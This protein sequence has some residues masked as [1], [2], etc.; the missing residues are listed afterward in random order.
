MNWRNLDAELIPDESAWGQGWGGKSYTDEEL[1]EIRSNV[2][3]STQPGYGRRLTS[4]AQDWKL[5]ATGTTEVF[6]PSGYD[7]AGHPNRAGR[8]LALM[9][10]DLATTGR[11][12][13]WPQQVHPGI[14]EWAQ[15]RGWCIDQ[16]G[17]PLH[18]L[19]EQLLGDRSIGMPTGLG[20][21]WY[22]GEAVVV[23]AVVT[24]RG[25]TLLIDRDTDRGTIPALSGGYATPADFGRTPAQWRAGDR[26]VT[27]DGIIAAAA[28]KAA[29]ETGLA[30]PRWPKPRLM[31]GCRPISSPHTLH[32]WTAT[33]TVWFDLGGDPAAVDRSTS[34]RWVIEDDLEDEMRSM[35]RD[36]R[37]ALETTLG[38]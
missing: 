3:G 16:H 29:E 2:T 14:R 17:R 9:D 30:L 22:Y 25:H 34:A 37:R 8:P 36:H 27:S 20:Y 18:P 33:V 12:D 4:S 23:D 24:S 13:Q 5:A 31:R 15:V 1:D 10:P 26:V 7:C 28:R 21:G 35:W 11:G 19:H 38:L 32:F 6:V